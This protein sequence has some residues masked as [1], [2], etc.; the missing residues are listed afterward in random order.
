[1][2]SPQLEDGFLRVA[3]EFMDA[4]C[5][6]DLSGGEFRVVLAVMRLTWGFREKSA[7]IRQDVLR[8]QAGIR[9]LGYLSR[10]TGSLAAKGILV[11]QTCHGKPTVYAIN[12]DYETWT[13]AQKCSTDREVSTDQEV[14]VSTD[15]VV[16]TGTDREVKSV[17]TNSPS[18]TLVLKTSLKDMSKD[19][20][21]DSALSLLSQCFIRLYCPASP[22]IPKVRND[23]RRL[24]EEIEDFDEI[25]AMV[26]LETYKARCWAPEQGVK[27]LYWFKAKIER[28]IHTGQ[29][30]GQESQKNGGRNGSRVGAFL[31]QGFQPYNAAGK[32]Y[33]LD[34]S[35]IYKTNTM[36]TQEMIDDEL[37]KYERKHPERVVVN[38]A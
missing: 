1:M 25:K 11:R 34:D 21:K 26:V 7:K 22:Q 38:D 32:T 33:Y 4:L 17:L 20:S 27:P 9:D 28:Y 29:L 14:V 36:P 13:I 19:M 18:S 5:C 31:A 8:K 35:M 23:D 37:D 3:N 16:S 2:A 24:R 15:Q 10:L 6:A 30:P 12:K